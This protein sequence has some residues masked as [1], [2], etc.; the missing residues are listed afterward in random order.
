MRR[1]PA[2]WSAVLGLVAVSALM[3]VPGPAAA[4]SGFE[5]SGTCDGASVVVPVER[6]DLEPFVPAGFTIAGEQTGTVPFALQ[7]FD[8]RDV[9]IAGAA[10]PPV[11][12]S[13]ALVVLDRDRS[14]ALA[15]QPPSD[16]DFYVVPTPSNSALLKDQLRVL[17]VA[18]E[19]NRRM[20]FASSETAVVAHATG[21]APRDFSIQ[22]T[23]PRRFPPQNGRICCTW[24]VGRDGLVRT[25]FRLTG[26]TFDSGVGALTAVPGSAM[27]RILGEQPRKDGVGVV[28][29]LS[30]TGTVELAGWPS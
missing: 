27:H 6:E 15:G 29:S 13:E 17:G 25:S 4:G 28:R 22:A 11:I 5:W 23:A 18:H 9:V 12:V 20:T 10:S 8:C 1:T 14:P 21:S 30:F 19:V 24:Q 26:Q 3:L 7:V 2:R 16:I